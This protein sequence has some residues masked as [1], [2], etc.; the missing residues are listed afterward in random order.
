MSNRFR[1]LVKSF[2]EGLSQ[3][4]VDVDVYYREAEDAVR[5]TPLHHLVSV[6]N[7][8]LRRHLG[9][10][11][12]AELDALHPVLLAGALFMAACESEEPDRSAAALFGYS[13]ASLVGGRALDAAVFLLASIATTRGRSSTAAE[14]LK[15]IGIDLEGVVNFACGA[16]ELAK[17]LENRGIGPIPDW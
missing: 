14:L 16:V 3:G 1:D 11:L 6:F 12:D 9:V 5:K 8:A 17:F 15:K 13:Y 7:E 2:D 10:A 4:T